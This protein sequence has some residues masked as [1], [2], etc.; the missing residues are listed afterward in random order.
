MLSVRWIKKIVC[1]D[2]IIE[3]LENNECL[4]YSFG[5]EDD[6]SFED[7]MDRIGSTVFAF[8]PTVDFPSER[9]HHINDITFE[10]I[11]LRAKTD[12]NNNLY[13]LFDMLKRNIHMNKKIYFL[14]IDIE[15]HELAGLPAWYESSAFKNVQRFGFE[16]H[17]KAAKETV[18]LFKTIRDLTLNEKFRLFSYDLNGRYA[19]CQKANYKDAYFNYAEIVL[20]RFNEEHMCSNLVL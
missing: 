1:M 12:E 4:I 10:K 7:L 15:G 6:W 18:S 13:S 14:K 2:D 5:I 20:K 19:G 16:Y 11:G 8:D 3:G 9:G 17:L